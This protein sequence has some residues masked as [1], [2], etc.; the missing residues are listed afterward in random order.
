ML[1]NDGGRRTFLV[2]AARHFTGCD[3]RLVWWWVLAGGL[4]AAGIVWRR[5]RRRPAD[6]R[7]LVAKIER[8]NPEVR[9]LLSTA[10][11]QEPDPESGSLVICNCA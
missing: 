4:M 7:A 3:T 2:S 8:E 9:H 1:G 6:F 10:A 5:E 11:E